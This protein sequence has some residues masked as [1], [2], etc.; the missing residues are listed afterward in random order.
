MKTET[1][2]D[3]FDGYEDLKNKRIRFV[4]DTSRGENAEMRIKEDYL[5]IL[6]I[7]SILPA[8]LY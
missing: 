5:R 8:Y 2:V 7:L 6:R 1:I 3:F 4:C